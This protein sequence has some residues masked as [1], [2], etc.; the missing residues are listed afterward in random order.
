MIAGLPSIDLAGLLALPVASVQVVTVNNRYARRLL[1][2]YADGLGAGRRVRQIPDIVPW[3]AWVRRL[4]DDLAFHDDAPIATGAID[5]LGTELLWQK[6]ISAIETDQALALLDVAQAARLAADA[7]SVLGE[8]AITVEPVDETEDYRRFAQW[9][10]AYRQVAD[11]LDVDDTNRLADR[12]VDALADALVRVSAGTVVFV[13]FQEFSPRQL[14]MVTALQQAGT[15][16]CALVVD[17]G[18]A[19]QV[20][21]VVADTPEKEW[22]L[23]ADW[24]KNLLCVN[25][26]GRYAVI[27]PQL[28]A[29]AALAHRVLSETL[30]NEHPYNVAVGRPLAD[31]PFGRAALAW[32]NLV[33]AWQV[34]RPQAG[35]AV[36]QV[37]AA[38]LAGGCVGHVREADGRARLDAQWRIDRRV[39]ITQ[40]EFQDDLARYAPGLADAWKDARAIVHAGGETA[41]LTQWAGI[42]R[43]ALEALGF[44]GDGVL[45]SDAYQQI[46]AFDALFARLTTLALVEP[47]DIPGRHAFELLRRLAQDTLFQPR[48]DPRARLDVLGFLEAEGGRWDAVWVLGLT[49]EVLPAAPRP[50]PFIPPA[51]LRR[52]NAPRATPER[53]L[54]WAQ[55]M[56][57]ALLGCGDR[58]I[59]SHAA[60]EGERQLRPSPCIA[61]FPVE[62]VGLSSPAIDPLPLEAVPDDHGP[63]L[64]TDAMTSGG[65]GVIDTQSRNPL[66][67]FVRYRLGA[68]SMPG[69]AMLPD[70]QLR[71]QFIHGIAE[72]VWSRLRHSSQLND[73]PLPDL[74]AL[75]AQAALAAAGQHLRDYSPVVRTLELK[76]GQAVMLDWL[77]QERRRPPFDVQSVE[78][79]F[80]WEHGP[81]RL[82]LRVDRIDQLPD[83]HL[84]LIDY[85][86]GTGKLDPKA[87][88]SR[89]RPVSLQLPFYAAMLATENQPVTALAFVQLHAREI[90][91]KG[92]AES[93]VGL[94]GLDTPNDW[95]A[96]AGMSWQ[97]VLAGWGQTI[98]DLADEFSQGLAVNT[99]SEA[100]LAR[101]LR[102]CNVIP[103]L[104]LYEVSPNDDQ[105]AQ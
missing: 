99:A 62:N 64:S 65:I 21:R 24:A 50:N 53:E 95:E 7:D 56:F 87:D 45:D 83:G 12:V 2:L 23:A 101:D 104:R 70:S 102:Y 5:R 37:G 84:L 82:G 22:R 18:P 72:R 31:W 11:A 30:A 54:A 57:A 42:F 44:P 16:V 17:N 76:R 105:I 78:R 8:W 68:K 6:V 4:A 20:G 58:V 38:L 88:W 103:F 51:V 46:E 94:E 86:T 69:Y 60:F 34:S 59:V 43:Q 26:Q 79:A 89:A 14:R 41:P 90:R 97:Q 92:L 66:W 35:V 36:D 29:D 32:L 9:R 28:Q 13:G 27:A 55:S 100:D 48:R 47:G 80:V 81:L 15:A 67:A 19:G 74:Q 52:A 73:M 91:I 98:R 61:S 3:G 71:G 25:P 85:K 40:V 1:G 49:D 10:H 96:L 39:R 93:D 75:V 33:L 77:L 63:P